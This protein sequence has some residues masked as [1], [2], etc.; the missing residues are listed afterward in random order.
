MILNGQGAT[1]Y[2]VLLAV[3][4]IVALVSVALLG[5]FPGMS[6]DAKIAQSQVYW[7]GQAS[8]FR[9]NDFS[10][11]AD[12]SGITTACSG[13]ARSYLY[14]LK[15]EN[16]GVE[17]YTITV[18]DI[19]IGGTYYWW[20]SPYPNGVVNQVCNAAG[21]AKY[22]DSNGAGALRS[23]TAFSLAPGEKVLAYID[24]PT[25][26][27]KCSGGATKTVEANIKFTYTTP[28]GLTKTQNGT[29]T[30]VFRCSD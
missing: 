26:T 11:V 22:G 6:G 15:I 24:S 17:K 21:T 4:L 5:F 10:Y 8:P 12:T 25:V 30:Y 16:A 23:G 20:A 19:A 29:R 2:L 18:I 28:G 1:E 14:A 13:S 3:V 7:S 27:A 9:I